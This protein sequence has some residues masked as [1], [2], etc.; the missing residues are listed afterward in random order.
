M[1]TVMIAAVLVVLALAASAAF[2]NMRVVGKDL[3]PIQ[4]GVQYCVRYRTL[5][6]GIEQTCTTNARC[7]ADAHVG[8]R[9][10]ETCR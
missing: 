1:R 9:L 10:P 5:F 7:F 4:E 8:D 2:V 3:R 6:G